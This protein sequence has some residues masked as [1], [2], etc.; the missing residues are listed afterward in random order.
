[1]STSPILPILLCPIGLY[2]HTSLGNLASGILFRSAVHLYLFSAIWLRILNI[3]KSLYIFTVKHVPS[4]ATCNKS[5]DVGIVLK[6]FFTGIQVSEPY[7]TG[8]ASTPYK[9]Q[10]SVFHCFPWWCHK[11]TDWNLSLIHIWL[12]SMALPKR[13]ILQKTL[14]YG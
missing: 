13:L 3:L 2:C 14:D 8:A 7:R 10:P 11:L 1:M 6:C 4:W 5:S 12:K 9:I